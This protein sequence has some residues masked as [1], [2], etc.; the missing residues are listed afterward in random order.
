MIENLKYNSLLHFIH[1]RWGF[2]CTFKRWQKAQTNLFKKMTIKNRT[3]TSPYKRKKNESRDIKFIFESLK[4]L[5]TCYVSFYGFICHT[6]C[7]GWRTIFHLL[8]R[9][10]PPH[11]QDFQSG[12]DEYHYSLTPICHLL[13]TEQHWAL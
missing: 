13:S 12:R 2:L 7:E 4:P 8:A 9:T 6:I 10:T 5:K 3:V 11:W 1:M